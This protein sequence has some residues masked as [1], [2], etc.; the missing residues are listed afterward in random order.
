MLYL[1][2]NVDTT[3]GANEG[4]TSAISPKKSFLIICFEQTFLKWH[5]TMIFLRKEYIQTDIIDI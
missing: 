2:I 5:W 1:F 3:H 4:S